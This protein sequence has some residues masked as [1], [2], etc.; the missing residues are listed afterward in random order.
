MPYR[1][2]VADDE[3]L[4]RRALRAILGAEGM[5]EAE[6]LEAANGREA[7]AL[8]GK[9]RLDVAFLDIRMPGIDGIEAARL[10]RQGRPALPVVLLT[11]H[12]T[13]EY[14]RTALRLRIDDF[15]LKPASPEEVRAAYLKALAA[16]EA[17]SARADTSR[18]TVAKVESALEYLEGEIRSSLASGRVDVAA[19]DKFHALA[20]AEGWVSAVVDV[21][22]RT[23]GKRPDAVAPLVERAFTARGVVAFSGARAGGAFCTVLSRAGPP[24]DEELFRP[25]LDGIVARCRSELGA[26]VAIG[27]A[28]ACPRAAPDDLARAAQRAAALAGPACPVVVLSLSAV[29]RDGPGPAERL[30]PLAGGEQEAGRSGRRTASR[31]LELLDGRLS[32]DLSLERVAADLRVSPSHLSRVLARHAGMGFADCLARLR[33][34]RAKSFL[35]SGAVAVK[36]AAAAVGFRDPAYFARVFRRFEGLSPADYRDGLRAPG[37]PGHGQGKEG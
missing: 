5:P 36:E 1:V 25:L 28:V 33:V 16:A 32:E 29:A 30:A 14:A 10:L 31:A 2:L 4:E 15:L 37:D 7:L 22:C 3:E 21:R 19:F 13:F 27:A 11:A 35:A 18:A 20:G 24:H 6:I 34:E 12:D 9:G 8:A 23:E 26:V 17:A